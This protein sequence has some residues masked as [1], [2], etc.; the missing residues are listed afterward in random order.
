MVEN[1]K[2]ILVVDDEESV[3]TNLRRILERVGYK[4]DTA[5]SGQ[6]ALAKAKAN[7]FDVILID[8]RLPDIS[9][10][11][12]LLKLPKKHEMVK[13]VITGYSTIEAGATAADYGADDFLVKPVQPQELLRSIEDRLAKV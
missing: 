11:D 9:G 3:R 12:L 1:A 10:T 7:C 6:E 5:S 4:V 8:I 13:I 2:S